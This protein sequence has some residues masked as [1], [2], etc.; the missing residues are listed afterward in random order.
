MTPGQS[1]GPLP[2]MPRSFS[3]VEGETLAQEADGGGLILLFDVGV[4]GV[5]DADIRVPPRQR[6]RASAAVFRK[7]VSKRFKRFDGRRGR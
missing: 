6:R 7:N 1:M 4:E 5:V 2:A 3:Q